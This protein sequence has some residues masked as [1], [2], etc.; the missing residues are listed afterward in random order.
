MPDAR[1]PAEHELPIPGPDMC[2]QQQDR[3][4]AWGPQ[5]LIPRTFRGHVAR[6]G[7]DRS[8]LQAPL[9]RHQQRAP[10][11]ARGFPLGSFPWGALYARF[12]R[13]STPQAGPPIRGP[14][15]RQAPGGLCKREAEGHPRPSSLLSWT[16]IR[17]ITPSHFPSSSSPLAPPIMDVELHSFIIDT[18][19]DV[20]FGVLLNPCFFPLL[21]SWC[22]DFIF[23]LAT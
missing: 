3:M 5:W 14:P 19:K 12:L 9:E 22:A 16:S 2:A 7:Q 20:S 1:P 21:L 10:A 11:P 15:P 4:G 18:Q 17:I 13:A 8:W 6:C 23:F